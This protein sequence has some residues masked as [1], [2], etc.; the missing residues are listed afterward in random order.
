LKELHGKVLQ[1]QVSAATVEALVRQQLW[2]YGA[3]VTGVLLEA[4][5]RQLTTGQAVH[6]R[7]TRAVLT[8]FG[9]V[10]LTRSRCT[11]GSYPLD[12]ALGLIG[13]HAWTTGVQEAVSLLSCECGFETTGELMERLLGLVIR[14]PSVQMVAEEAGRRAQ[15]LVVNS[16]PAT[17]LAAGKTLMVAIDG[18]QAPQRDGWHEV[19]VAT[20]YVNE[21]RC[22]K[23]SG[24]GK[25]LSKEYV[26]SLADAEGFGRQ[27]W[28]RAQQW[29]VERARRVVCMGD[30]APWIWNLAAEHFP[31]AV[32][33]VDFYHAVEHLWTVGEALWGDRER[34]DRTRRW[35]RHYRRQLK[36]GRVD[37]VIDALARAPTGRTLSESASAVV[38]RNLEYFR[39]NRERMRYDLYRRAGLPM[40]T[41]MVEGSCKFVVQSRFKRP[42]SRWSR[43]GLERMLDL[44][45]LRLNRHWELLWPHL[46]AA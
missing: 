46:K 21:T 5:D 30:G 23:T 4:L 7:R 18:C 15:P 2:H 24:R 10:D 16:P 14:G 20:V 12:E 22:R 43:E 32:E 3:Q 26:A 45:L 11:D 31:G 8:L 38:R 33:I 28:R 35:V 36:G 34:S 27:L 40:G 44:K 6:D 13:R 39:T 29:Q 9:P 17:D 1:G 25:V 19:K 42:G 37:L 41:G